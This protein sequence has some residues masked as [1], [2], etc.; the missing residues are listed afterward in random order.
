MGFLWKLRQC[1]KHV[2][3]EQGRKGGVPGVRNSV[4]R[5]T[6]GQGRVTGGWRSDCRSQREAAGYSSRSQA[7]KGVEVLVWITGG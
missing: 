2:G 6:E 3:A 5:S 7:F 4:G 1:G